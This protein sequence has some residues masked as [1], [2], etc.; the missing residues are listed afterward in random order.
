MD[1]RLFQKK[2]QRYGISFVNFYFNLTGF[3]Y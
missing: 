1:L 3:D 2:I